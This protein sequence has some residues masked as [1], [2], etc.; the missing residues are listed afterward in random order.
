MKQN[1]LVINGSPREKKGNSES[2]ADCLI[3]NLNHKDQ[4]C[5][6][7]YLSYNNLNNIVL[8]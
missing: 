2:I 7:V 3:D 8:K 6:K 5:T 1:I 4:A